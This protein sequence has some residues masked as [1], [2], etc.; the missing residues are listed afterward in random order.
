LTRKRAN[1]TVRSTR[2]SDF[3][4]IVAL[5]QLVYPSAPP[6]T[7]KQLQS[8][9]QIFPDGQLVAVDP[10]TEKIVGMAA[11]LVIL[12][13]D[14]EVNATWR[15]MT[16]HG[17]FTNHDPSGRT[18]YGAEIMV[19][20]SV[21]GRGIGKAIYRARRDLA[22]RLRLRR[23][24]AGARLRGYHLYADRFGADEYVRRVVGGELTDPTLTFQLRQHFQPI[25]VVK[26]YL[27]YDPESLGYAALIEWINHDVAKPRDYRGRVIVGRDQ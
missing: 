22:R 10:E 8:H 23:I 5:T 13:D 11:S 24:R 15:E 26:D 25:A 6:W 9:H 14:Y 7:A 19:D 12:W 21:Q 20:P 27:R 17:M 1:V 16:D 3:D 18:L 2:P 4:G